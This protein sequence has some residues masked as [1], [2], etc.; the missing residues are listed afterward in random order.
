L[1]LL[2]LNYF[3]FFLI[4]VFGRL[5]GSLCSH[6]SPPLPNLK[7]E[8]QRLAHRSH[9]APTR[10]DFTILELKYCSIKAK[11]HPLATGGWV[12]LEPLEL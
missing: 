8:A 11:S 3:I 5:G 6:A 1:G 10:S 2:L 12:L 9:V 4:F 7:Q